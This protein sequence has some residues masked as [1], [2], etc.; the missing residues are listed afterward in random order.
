METACR[1]RR[2]V[3]WTARSGLSLCWRLTGSECRDHL[4]T[5][6][7]PHGG[8]TTAA[9][10]GKPAIAGRHFTLTFA[11]RYCPRSVSRSN[12]RRGGSR[13]RV[14]FQTRSTLRRIHMTAEPG[15]LHM[16][17]SFKQIPG[18]S[19]L[20]C[21][22][23]VHKMPQ[24]ESTGE[25]IAVGLLIRIPVLLRPQPAGVVTGWLFSCAGSFHVC[26]SATGGRSSFSSD[27]LRSL[28]ALAVR[29]RLPG[30]FPLLPLSR[31][32]CPRSAFRQA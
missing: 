17:T 19:I 31:P 15:S 6:T 1:V 14:R 21:G 23:S 8:S 30:R 20:S 12:S 7:Q 16:G 3:W 26:P 29:R 5:G 2:A 11:A 32:A 22:A 24:R 25:Q 28:E 10:P 4:W 27:S 9:L 18:S 13:P